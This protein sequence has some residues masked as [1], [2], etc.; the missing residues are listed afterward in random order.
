MTTTIGRLFDSGIPNDIVARVDETVDDLTQPVSAGAYAVKSLSLDA[1]QGTLSIFDT[2]VK[3]GATATLTARIAA[4]TETF[5]PFDEGTSIQA[6][7]GTSYASLALDAKLTAAGQGGGKAGVLAISGEASA[8]AQ[9]AYLHL[10]PVASTATRLNA[11]M[12]LALTTQLPQLANFSQLRDGESLHFDALL[13][14]DLGIKAQYGAELDINDTIDVAADLPLPVKAHA[15]F[16]A[17]ASL[18]LSLYGE[19]SVTVA[20]AGQRN[21]GF[22]RIRFARKRSNGITFGAAFSLAVQYDAATGVNALLDKTFAQLQMPKAVTDLQQFLV[23][24]TE[25]WPQLKEKISAK[26]ADT[27]VTLVGDTGWKQWVDDDPRIKQLL[28]ASNWIVNEYNS[29]DGKIKSLWEELLARLDDAGFAKVRARITELAALDVNSISVESLTGGKY[30]NIIDLIELLSG[31]D[32]ESLVISSKLK[33]GI[34]RAVDVAKRFDAAVNGAP[35][36]AIAYLRG[37][38]TRTGIAPVVAWLQK[39][40]T[41]TASLETAADTWMHNVVER[42]VDKELDK[43]DAGDVARLQAFAGKVQKLLNTPQVVEAKIRK[44]VAKL[45]GDFTVSLSIEMS[46]VS[47]HSALV[48]L[49]F[50]P[51]KSDVTDAVS[52]FLPSGNVQPLLETLGKA[53]AASYDIR[54][55]ILTS[56]HLRTSTGALMLSF[57]GTNINVQ[58]SRLQEETISFEGGG[59]VPNKRTAVYAG[60]NTIRRTDTGSTMEGAAFMRIEATSR[61]L[62]RDAK[63]DTFDASIRLTFVREDSNARDEEMKSLSDLLGDLGMLVSTPMA[64]AAGQT[65]FAVELNLPAA[66]LDALIRDINDEDGW[67]VDMRNAAT[68]WFRDAGLNPGD[69]Q[70]GQEMATVIASN[71]FTDTW[72]DPN[73]FKTAAIG[74]KFPVDIWDSI[75]GRLQMK[76]TPLQ[77]FNNGRAMRY[78]R[79]QDFKPLMSGSQPLPSDARKVTALAAALFSIGAVEWP[80]PLLNFWLVLSRLS[81]IAPEALKDARGVATLRSR[82]NAQADWSDP[83][84]FTLPEGVGVWTAIRNRCFQIT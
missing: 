20:K 15:A 10:L 84:W 6:P 73:A 67:N 61:N 38:A 17:S 1:G 42:L 45:K 41:S 7:A 79:Y 28:D 58:Q 22:V 78:G 56:R 5:Q 21:P 81:R 75:Q 18:G 46:R 26:V 65:R 39:N 33:E 77:P 4:A 72:T 83:Q 49:E 63:Y 60:G 31:H 23:L 3:L 52:R 64:S 50:D 14:L 8:N 69:V 55:L 32:I 43:I 66:A 40:A 70:R 16:T 48:D 51:T 36:K 62:D 44:A 35:D 82:A 76:Y 68:R 29:L 37:F 74:R 80:L 13:N 71:T 34:Q 9:L 24:A 12:D 2:P 47:E 54:E 27:V 30:N 53:N 57:L 59:S 19:G 11:L 25:P